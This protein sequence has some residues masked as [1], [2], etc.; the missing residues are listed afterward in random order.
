MITWTKGY[1]PRSTGEF[2][3]RL[4]MIAI[5]YVIAWYEGRRPDGTQRWRFSLDAAYLPHQI[6]HYTKIRD[7]NREQKDL[8]GQANHKLRTIGVGGS[9]DTT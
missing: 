2:L 9:R 3:V 4:D 5:Y 6:T 8:V 7:L 1:K